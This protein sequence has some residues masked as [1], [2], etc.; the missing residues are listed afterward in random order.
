MH[1]GNVRNQSG[2]WV[3][4]RCIDVGAQIEEFFTRLDGH[5]GLL[6][7]AIT[8]TF[9]DTIDRALNLPRTRTDRRQAV[10]DSHAEIV[11]AVNT[12]RNLVDACNMLR[13]IAK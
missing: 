4:A 13:Q 10:C 7:T 6:K 1:A 8:R 12:E 5:D 3:E 9:T 2:S 11:M